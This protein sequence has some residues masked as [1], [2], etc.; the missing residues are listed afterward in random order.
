MEYRVTDA[1]DIDM[2]MDVR[3]SMLRIVNDLPADYIFDDELVVSSRRYFL[4]GD[5]TTVV[6]VNDGRCVACASMSYIEI[7]PTFSHSSGKRAHLMNVYT[8]ESYRRRG[9]A[10][11]L[12]NMLIED[13]RV[14]GA[15]EISLDATESGR[16]LYESMGFKASEECMVIDIQQL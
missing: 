7:M 9:I 5:Q 11:Q 16:P 2:L 8:E 15:T 6:A 13:A 4:E 1:N 14:H 10:R 3:L 12:V